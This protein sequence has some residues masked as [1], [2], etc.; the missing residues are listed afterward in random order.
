MA[1]LL[2]NKIKEFKQFVEEER[3]VNEEELKNF[4]RK[5]DKENNIKRENITKNVKPKTFYEELNNHSVP[6]IP[7]YNNAKFPQ[8]INNWNERSYYSADFENATGIGVK[9]GVSDQFGYSYYAIDLDIYHNVQLK[10][11]LASY[12]FAKLG[13]SSQV[14]EETIS[15]GI[16]IWFKIKNTNDFSFNYKCFNFGA[17]NKV[18]I[19]GTNHQVGT[20][21]TTAL[22]KNAELG[23]YKLFN[24]Y[25]W[26]ADIVDPHIF[27]SFLKDFSD[28]NLKLFPKMK[29][30]DNLILHDKRKI[31]IIDKNISKKISESRLLINEC[32][33][34]QI[35]IKELMDA[36]NVKYIEYPNRFDIYSP[37]K[38]N[39]D[40]NNPGLTVYNN[41]IFQIIDFHE[42]IS[43]SW[44]DLIKQYAKIYNKNYKSVLTEN[45]NIDID[46]ILNPDSGISYSK[47]YILKDNQKLTSYMNVLIDELSQNNRLNIIANT[48]TGKTTAIV[49]IYKNSDRM[50]LF[51][52]PYIAN[53][54]QNEENFNCPAV[55]GEILSKKKHPKRFIKTLLRQHKVVF[56]TYDT[57]KHFDKGFNYQDVDLVIDEYHNLIAQY[58][59][60]KEILQ[61]IVA[62]QN[63]FEKIITLTGT[64][65]NL[66]NKS[67]KFHKDD[68]RQFLYGLNDFRTIY[69]EK[70]N[71]DK[72]L[73][74]YLGEMKKEEAIA[75]T[76]KDLTNKSL[77]KKHIIF[78]N[79]KSD[80][81]FMKQQLINTTFYTEDEIAILTSSHENIYDT[82]N[83][84]ITFDI[85]KS[86]QLDGETYQSLVERNYIPDNVKI[87]LTTQV[88]SDGVNILNEN[89]DNVYIL[90]NRNITT[91]EQFLA[92]FRNGFNNLH[93]YFEPTGVDPNSNDTEF[94]EKISKQLAKAAKMKNLTLDED[95]KSDY[96]NLLNVINNVDNTLIYDE[97]NEIYIPNN[98]RIQYIKMENFNRKLYSSAENLA[99]FLS[100]DSVFPYNLNIEIVNLEDEDKNDK[101][102]DFIDENKKIKKEQRLEYISI[103]DK[104]ISKIQKEYGHRVNIN[105]YEFISDLIK[106]YKI[107]NV[108]LFKNLFNQYLELY[109]LGLSSE[110][111]MECLLNFKTNTYN[112]LVRILKSL[113]NRELFNKF[114]KIKRKR[115]KSNVQFKIYLAIKENMQFIRRVED[116]FDFIKMEVGY[117]K[118]YFNKSHILTIVRSYFNVRIANDGTINWNGEID[119]DELDKF[120]NKKVS[121]LVKRNIKSIVSNIYKFDFIKSVV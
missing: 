24:D 20:Y 28:L 39:L 119:Y 117:I 109:Y 91:T 44:V 50:C 84:Y 58:D 37:F 75:Y 82:N 65:Y 101:Y 46:K 102:Q 54:K 116:I 107:R 62:K 85:N 72:Q 94:F 66:F 27:V 73:N 26:N 103:I 81:M 99:L 120:F 2:Q 9:T 79:N 70:E 17:K 96:L 68:D 34:N 89:I 114:G 80:L 111:I 69:F 49:N 48:G 100:N 110:E 95:N 16:H 35:T 3:D 29:G 38:E 115:S 86:I 21:P 33:K 7:Y 93:I 30:L 40:G 22:N 108:P 113:F 74:V 43:H 105:D 67:S 19:F 88:I 92:R 57:I 41:N 118:E 71:I 61:M 97:V 47:K 52:V 6:V 112:K 60:R 15:G 87:L 23:K 32:M 13:F 83:R 63:Y 12:I 55:Y 53:A 25:I 121:N 90:N 64:P 104:E 42:N 31:N 98:I 8:G 4:L 56:A 18:E 106:I 77:N 14:Y 10:S 59:F 51:L 1:K 78:L 45:F 5:Y 36:F 76:L 11:A